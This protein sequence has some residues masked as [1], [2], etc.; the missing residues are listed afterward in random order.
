MCDSRVHFFVLFVYE[1]KNTHNNLAKSVKVDFIMT[2]HN[3][4]S[5]QMR[6][7]SH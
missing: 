7:R 5:S 4:I 6:V 3:K 1:Y 2:S